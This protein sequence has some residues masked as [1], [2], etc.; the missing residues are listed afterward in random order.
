[1]SLGIFKKQETYE[2]A[3]SHTIDKQLIEE[4]RRYINKNYSSEKNRISQ[5]VNK[6]SEYHFNGI[7]AQVRKAFDFNYEAIIKDSDYDETFSQALL[8]LI[9]EKGYTDPE[10]YNKACIDR[11]LF[12]KIRSNKHYKPKKQTAIAFAIAL[13]LDLSETEDLLKKAGYSLSNSIK[14][15]IIIKYFITHSRYDIFEINEAL[16]ELDQTLL[17]REMKNDK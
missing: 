8:R 15:D 17:F 4:I 11:K 5:H 1:M 9:D 2:K 10:V 13:E 14:F 16:R 12:S 6:S 3:S 7:S